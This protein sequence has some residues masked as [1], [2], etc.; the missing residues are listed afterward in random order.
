MGTKDGGEFVRHEYQAT[1]GTDNGGF[2]EMSFNADLNK[3]I[4]DGYDVKIRHLNVK[5]SFNVAVFQDQ[6]IKD[7]SSQSLASYASGQALENFGDDFFS[8]VFR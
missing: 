5:T 2:K 1:T 4:F 7:F 8:Q 6:V 3:V